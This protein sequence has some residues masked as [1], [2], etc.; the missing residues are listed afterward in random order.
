MTDRERDLIARVKNLE[1]Q[2]SKT[3]ATADPKALSFIEK[4]AASKSK[5]AAEAR[6]ILGEE[7]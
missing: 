3:S 4:I 1:S 5:F 6:E 7:S 2:L